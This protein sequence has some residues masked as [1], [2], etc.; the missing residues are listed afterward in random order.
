MCCFLLGSSTE[1]EDDT[2]SDDNQDLTKSASTH[3]ETEA[4]TGTMRSTANRG[5]MSAERF[6]MIW[7]VVDNPQDPSNSEFVKSNRKYLF[8]SGKTSL[9]NIVL[10]NNENDK[11]TLFRV[12]N[13]NKAGEPTNLKEVVHIEKAREIIQSM[14]RPHNGP[15]LPAGITKLKRQFIMKYYLK[16]CQHVITQVLSQC[17]GTCR[18]TKVLQTSAPPPI[19]VRSSTIMERIQIDLLH[20]MYGSGSPFNETAN[21]NYR[22]I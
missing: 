8:E 19:P 4:L 5:P 6:Q 7:M 9:P 12:I 1:C 3:V 18:R 14:H 13:R 22:V 10:R 20:I 11:R 21:H 15:C 2:Q 17:Q 16:G